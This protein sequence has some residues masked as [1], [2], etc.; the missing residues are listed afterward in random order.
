MD[1]DY[2]D[3][4]DGFDFEYCSKCDGH[5]ACEDYGCAFKAGVGHLVQI[6]DMNISEHL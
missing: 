5:P 6:T 2:D 4:E 3:Y 1:Q